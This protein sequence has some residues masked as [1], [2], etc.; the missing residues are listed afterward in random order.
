MISETKLDTSFPTGQFHIHNFSEPHRFDRKGNLCGI[1]PYMREYIATKLIL[2][3]TTRE[4]FF[5][6]INLRKKVDPLLLI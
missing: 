3:K 4:G 6:K 2:T 1:L 5:V